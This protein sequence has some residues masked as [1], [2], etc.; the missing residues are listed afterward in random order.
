MGINDECVYMKCNVIWIKNKYGLYIVIDLMQT[1]W[2]REPLK[3]N[4]TT[5]TPLYKRT[6]VSMKS[7]MNSI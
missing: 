6:S 2:K 4:I 3:Y 1:I 7:Y 5:L